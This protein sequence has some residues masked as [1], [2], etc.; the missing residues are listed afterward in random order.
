MART[1]RDRMDEMLSDD[2]STEAPRTS[3]D[4]MDEMLEYS[5]DTDTGILNDVKRAPLSGTRLTNKP[6]LGQK[7]A[8]PGSSEERGQ[9][10][11]L[12]GGMLAQHKYSME[13][14]EVLDDTAIAMD[15]AKNQH[16]EG[17]F[18]PLAA[19]RMDMYEDEE[20]A[21]QVDPDNTIRNPEEDSFSPGEALRKTA[22]FLFS[23][24]IAMLGFKWDGEE[25]E[26]RSDTIKEQL[27]EHPYSSAI[28]LASYAIPIGLAAKAGARVAKRGEEIAKMAGVASD[29][30][31]DGMPVLAGAAKGSGFL[32][33]KLGFKFDDHSKIVKALADPKV[34][35]D[36]LT[37]EGVKTWGRGFFSPNMAKAI[38]EAKTS[39]D[40]AKLVTTK[41]LRSLL[42]G[43]AQQDAFVQLKKKVK[44]GAELTQKEKMSWFLQK[45]FQNTYFDG[46]QDVNKAK[47]ASMDNFWE[48]A[49]IGK[50]L[51]SAPGRLGEAGDQAVYKYWLDGS[52]RNTAELAEKIGE[53]N[54]IWAENLANKWTELFDEQ[55]ASGFVDEGTAAMFRDADKVG[56]GFHLPAILKGTPGFGD[57]DGQTKSFIS[58]RGDNL[59]KIQTTAGP[60]NIATQL[61]GPTSK[62]RGK[63][64]S[65]STVLE[66]IDQLETGAVAMTTGGFIKDSILFQIHKNFRDVIISGGDSVMSKEA[67]K[68]LP[69]DSA[70]KEWIGLD[71]LDGVVEGLG[72][73]MRNML[74]IEAERTGKTF[75]ADLPYIDRDVV[76]A[77]FGH[78]GSA[79]QTSGAFAKHF[80]LATA[81]HKTSKT[82]L[83]PATHAAN[84]AGNIL[85]L[86]MAGMNPLSKVSLNDGKVMT[87]AFI[88][89][90]RKMKKGAASGND[91]TLADVMGD[92]DALIDVFGDT[93]YITDDLG[94]QIDLVDF[95]S[96]PAMSKLIEAQAFDNVEGMANVKTMLKQFENAEENGWGDKS[97]KTLAAAI[98]G[99]TE[100][101]GIKPTLA[102]AS[103][104]YL[105]EDMI[106]KM[107]YAMNLARQGLGTDA[108]IREVG[109]RL[110]QYE[111]VGQLQKSA[112]KLV[113]PWVTFQAESARIIKNNMMDRPVQMMA[114]MQAPQIAQAAVSNAG[115]GT[116]F[117]DIEEAK[118]LAPDWANKKTSVM[119]KE[120]DAPEALGAIGG[121]F[122]GAMTGAAKG[123]ARGAAIGGIAGAAAG[124]AMGSSVQ[125]KADLEE[126]NRSWATDFFPQFALQPASTGADA[127]DKIDPFS[128]GPWTGGERARGL[129]DVSPVAPFAVVLP[130]IETLSGRG[131]FG[132]E[133]EAASGMEYG[134]KLALG[135]L[136]HLAPPFMQKYGMKLPGPDGNPISMAEIFDKNGGQST[137]PKAITATMGGLALG[138]LTFMG[139]KSLATATR[140]AKTGAGV[141][142]AT[143]ATANMAATAGAAG[144][145]ALAGSEVNV[146]RLMHDLGITKDHNKNLPG[147]WTQDFVGNNLFG[148][149]KSWRASPESNLMR[150]NIR[151][152]EWGK[153]KT[154]VNNNLKKAIRDGSESRAAGYLAA[155]YKIFI[156]QHGDT[157]T[158]KIKF[159]EWA[160]RQIK[161]INKNPAYK[162]LSNEALEARALEGGAATFAGHNEVSKTQKQLHSEV[163]KEQIMRNLDKAS[164]LVVV[165][166]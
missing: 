1:S 53:E 32:G 97:L 144:V 72:D 48:K 43:D 28:T 10:R 96:D 110:P 21:Y 122:A 159:H 63:Y 45:K 79:R 73:K 31:I 82:S 4:R 5:T 135:L 30:A 138:G 106:P 38:D 102:N 133:I 134:G 33:T 99:V 104:A 114:W 46:L 25:Y 66:N 131:S 164:G 142:G 56:S 59:N 119:L 94:G 39:E 153:Q 95:F 87:D 148:V 23:D 108:I 120:N 16:F 55:V 76:E 126:Y 85:F 139:T 8:A 129:L 92:K 158:A 166:E 11:A 69:S 74:K 17:T 100:N 130:I 103:A 105:A 141:L 75:D 42:L 132:E 64:T 112:R 91:I 14:Q 51:A 101:K 3:R 154:I 145:G 124:F 84:L 98:S 20:G 80:E 140:V 35:M 2:V 49:Q 15:D 161:S 117:E 61:G 152:K 70:R 37:E 9:F 163:L 109:R 157:P 127:M 12:A 7:K 71:E 22:Q 115:F 50:H 29:V 81:V 111:S 162:G 83:N 18:G 44:T 68:L 57:L 143:T 62:K 65:R 165:D 121:G 147:E 34:N 150:D 52:S 113:L 24:E 151:K 67:Y 160:V 155:G 88:N 137:L 54:S 156:K 41:R 6:N 90:T 93:R 77:F 47:I 128:Q 13:Q 136:G 27:T 89:M 78:N 146:N 116:P 118:E 36:G 107:M 86:Q 60:S 123:G 149:S 58:G 26:W 125:D 40:V 19:S